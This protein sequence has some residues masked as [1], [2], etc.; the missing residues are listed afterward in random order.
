MLADAKLLKTYLGKIMKQEILTAALAVPAQNAPQVA[1]GTTLAGKKAPGAASSSVQHL[2]SQPQA[3]PAPEPFGQEPPSYLPLDIIKQRGIDMRYDPQNV[4]LQVAPLGAAHPPISEFRKQRRNGQRRAGAARRGQRLSQ[5]ARDGVLCEPE[6]FRQH[7]LR[8]HH[9]GF[10]WRREVQG[11]R[12]RKRG[13][14]VR[15]RPPV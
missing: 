5:H 7:G 15:P 3:A 13:F 11:R 9:G 8:C 10:R 6:Q 1:G 12:D 14:A 2:A 4:E